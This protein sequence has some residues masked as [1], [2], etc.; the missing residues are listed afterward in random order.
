[1]ISLEFHQFDHLLDL[2]VWELVLLTVILRMNMFIIHV[3]NKKSALD[4]DICSERLAIIAI[5]T[6]LIAKL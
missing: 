4:E 1:M 5:V 6:F 3:N 2:L